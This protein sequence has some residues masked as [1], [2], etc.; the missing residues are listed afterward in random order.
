MILQRDAQR[1]LCF[2]VTDSPSACRLAHLASHLEKTLLTNDTAERRQILIVMN[3][4]MKIV[5]FLDCINTIMFRRAPYHGLFRKTEQLIVKL[6]PTG[7]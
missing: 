6:S 3:R 4:V 1:L 2:S 5:R 7:R